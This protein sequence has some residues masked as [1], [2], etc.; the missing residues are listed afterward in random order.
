MVPEMNLMSV[1]YAREEADSMI[2]SFK[3]IQSLRQTNNDQVI[4]NRGPPRLLFAP[5]R[6]EKDI[7]VCLGPASQTGCMQVL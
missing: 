5:L 4:C 7:F 6:K 3:V 1:D 2:S